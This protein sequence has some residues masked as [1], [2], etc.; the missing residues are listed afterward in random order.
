MGL[1][2]CFPESVMAAIVLG[3]S[4]F[5]VAWAECDYRV[6][7]IVGKTVTSPAEIGPDLRVSPARLRLRILLGVLAVL[8]R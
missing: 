3:Q 6:G 8:E 4:G 1:A 5:G 2:N 7:C